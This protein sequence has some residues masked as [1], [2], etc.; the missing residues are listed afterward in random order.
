MRRIPV[1]GIALLAALT[2]LAASC[3][4]RGESATSASHV[5]TGPVSERRLDLSNGP[6]RPIPT[7]VYYP[8]APGRSPVIVF[9]H[10]F[11]G[12][13]EDYIPLFRHWV[14]A[15]FVVIAPQHPNT[16][17]TCARQDLLD[18]LQQPGDDSAVLTAVLALGEKAGDPLRGRLDGTRVAAAGHSLG[19]MT[20]VGLLGRSRDPRLKAGIV[21]AGSARDVGTAFTGPPAS[22]LFIHGG[23][24]WVVPIESGRSAYEAVP[25]G[26]AFITLPEADHVDPYLYPTDRHFDVVADTTTDFLR[27][28][29][30]GD[31]A[32]RARLAADAA[33]YGT[34]EDRLG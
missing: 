18:L 25:W 3:G 21:L 12:M 33:G 19:G 23:W 7:I 15:G 9:S 6:D 8:T 32:A 13:P 17:R 2:T 20:V 24:D 28:A 26:K 11:T 1:A 31:T 34:V 14:Q 27:W 5:P 29:L 4:T 16:C 30:D 10:G 22:V